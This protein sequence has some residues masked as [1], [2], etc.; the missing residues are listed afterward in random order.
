[1]RT[2]MVLLALL[3]A[4]CKQEASFDERFADTEKSLREKAAQIDAELA[5][6]E[7]PV[8]SPETVP[9]GK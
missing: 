6:S 5:K 3:V 8:S 9:Q 7:K 1:M 4:G 2:A